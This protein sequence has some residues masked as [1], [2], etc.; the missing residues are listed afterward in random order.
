VQPILLVLA[1]TVA[2][3]LFFFLQMFVATKVCGFLPLVKKLLV[4]NHIGLKSN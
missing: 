4:C 3:Q 2:Q 1:V